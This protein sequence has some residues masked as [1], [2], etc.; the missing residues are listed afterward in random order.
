MNTKRK[1]GPHRW[2]LFRPL[3]AVCGPKLHTWKPLRDGRSNGKGS[4][5]AT[6]SI[7]MTTDMDR[8]RRENETDRLP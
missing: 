3:F 1:A 5:G 8:L 4:D 6:F 7:S 2:P